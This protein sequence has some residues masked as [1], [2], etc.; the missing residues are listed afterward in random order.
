VKSTHLCRCSKG[1]DMTCPADQPLASLITRLTRTGYVKEIHVVDAMWAK[2]LL[3]NCTNCS[4]RGGF[5][6]VGF[7]NKRRESTRVF[8]LCR[9]CA[10]WTEV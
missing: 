8:W 3:A 9:T 1:N 5:D 10:H 7:R 2:S 6:A 4:S